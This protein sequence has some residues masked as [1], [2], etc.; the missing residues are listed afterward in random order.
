MGPPADQA[1]RE[2]EL[3]AFD[4]LLI[5]EAIK[6]VVIGDQE[7]QATGRG[8]I[9]YDFDRAEFRRRYNRSLWPVQL[10]A[11]SLALKFVRGNDLD[12]VVPPRESRVAQLMIDRFNRFLKLLRSSAIVAIDVHNNLVH[13]SV[14][15]GSTYAICIQ[16]HH[17]YQ[18]PSMERWTDG[19]PDQENRIVMEHLRLSLP[20]NAVSK[21]ASDTGRPSSR[22]K[23]R[24]PK[25]DEVIKALK[26][27]G[28]NKPTDLENRSPADVAC[29]ISANLSFI[30]KRNNEDQLEA[31]RVMITRLRDS[32]WL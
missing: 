7:V 26:A 25:K 29:E 3:S 20:D 12:R 18:M 28:I 11:H 9:N 5:G 2:R 24:T 4:G 21:I 10:D 15:R 22:R 31:L 23:C 6:Q 8:L 16:M 19:Y 32:G 1:A 30:P 27:I 14:W 17:L 13:Q